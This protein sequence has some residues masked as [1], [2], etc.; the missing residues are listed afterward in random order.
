[1]FNKI[2]GLFQKKVSVQPNINQMVYDHL[3]AIAR[4]SLI[5]PIT[6]YKEARNVQSNADYLMKM[7]EEIKKNTNG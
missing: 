2:K 3:I 4:L 5:K 6:L 7:A 1:M